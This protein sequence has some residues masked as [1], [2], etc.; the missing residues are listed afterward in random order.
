M[1]NHDGWYDNDVARDMSGAGVGGFNIQLT[2]TDKQNNNNLPKG[3]C[4]RCE[5]YSPGF[6]PCHDGITGVTVQDGFGEVRCGVCSR[7]DGTGKEPPT[8]I[9]DGTWWKPW[10]WN[11]HHYEVL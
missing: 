8:R 3:V 1:G 7:C 2:G 9:F 6:G 4:R 11:K 10:T 5:G